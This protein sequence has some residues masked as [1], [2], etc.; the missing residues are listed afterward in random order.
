ML[1]SI[2]GK[3]LCGILADRIRP[4]I[5]KVLR[6]EQAGFRPNRG[7]SDQI[8]TLRRIIEKSRYGIILNFI[9]FEKAFDSVPQ[10]ALWEIL[11]S[12]GI[13]TKII[14]I[15]KSLYEDAESCVKVNEEANTAW[16]KIKTGVTQGCILSPLL[17]I[18][19]IDWVLQKALK[20]QKLGIKLNYKQE[21]EDQRLRCFGHLIKLDRDTLAKQILQWKPQAGETRMERP[22]TSWK[23]TITR[24]LKEMGLIYDKAIQSARNKNEWDAF[25][26]PIAP[27]GDWSNRQI[28]RYVVFPS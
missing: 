6:E 24:D 11:K 9:D 19:A 2:P 8:F 20:D 5:E 15:I 21:I 3:V 13:P 26:L 17:F 12:Y 25:S 28:A 18:I 7:C 27:N 22:P 4:E 1:L 14:E 23:E 16:F 10:E